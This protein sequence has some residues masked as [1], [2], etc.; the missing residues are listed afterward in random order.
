MGQSSSSFRRH[1]LLSHMERH[2][3]IR[4]YLNSAAEQGSPQPSQPLRTLGAARCVVMSGR[5]RL[6][7]LLLDRDGGV[8]AWMDFAGNR[9][10]PGGWEGNR[11]RVTGREVNT[12][13]RRELRR[14]AWGRGELAIRAGDKHMRT[15]GIRGII[16]VDGLSRLDRD[17]RIGKGEPAHVNGCRGCDA[18]CGG[19]RRRCRGRRRGRRRGIG[20]RG[21]GGAFAT[22]GQSEGAEKHQTQKTHRNF[23][24][25]EQPPRARVISEQRAH[26]RI[27]IG[28]RDGVT[29]KCLNAIGT[30]T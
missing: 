30:I 22:G 14:G 10:C 8:H 15:T 1:T 11:H 29:L 7:A 21:G 6:L 12:N 27:S 4:N 13:G 25:A 18:C 19:G 20:R 5:D 16:E 3:V 2:L 28:L 24:H 17:T 9:E 23:T 26:A